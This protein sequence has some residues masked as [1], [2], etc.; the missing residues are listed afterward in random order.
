MQK[1]QHGRKSGCGSN[2]IGRRGFIQAT[3]AAAVAASPV[4][5]ICVDSNAVTDTLLQTESVKP[6]LAGRTFVQLSTSTPQE[7]SYST[8]WMG[9][10]GASYL[11]GAIQCAPDDIGKDSAEF[12]LSGDE[13]AFK[14]V[15]DLL[16][17]LGG[18]LRYLGA[19]VRA[20]SV[21]DLAAVCESYGRF[22][23]VSHAARMCEAE[24]VGLDQLASLF[25]KGG[26]SQRYAEVIHTSNFENPSATIRIWDSAAQRIRMQARDAGINSDF[27]DYVTSLFEKAIAAGYGDEHVMALVKVLREEQ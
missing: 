14:G 26:F 9:A 11:D 15:S 4:I 22:M 18:T 3:G 13:D 20:A 17:S 24:G 25:S 21:L 10:L 2:G 8:E 19:N 16:T 1:Q 12:L 7:A 23:A 6:H 5:L 27:P